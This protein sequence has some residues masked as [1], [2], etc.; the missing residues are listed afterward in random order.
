[1]STVKVNLQGINELDFPSGVTSATT[2]D[3]ITTINLSGGG[4]GITELTGDVAAGPGSGTVA[5]TVEGIQ[6]VS[7]DNVTPQDQQVL[8]YSSTTSK[9]EPATLPASS[10]GTYFLDSASS[11]VV[12]YKLLINSFPTTGEV[13]YSASGTSGSGQ[14]LVAEF[15]GPVGGMG[16]TLIPAGMWEPSIFLSVDSLTQGPQAI[17]KIYTRTLAGVE[18]L[19]LTQNIILTSTSATLYDPT[20]E[21]GNIAVSPTDRMVVKVYLLAGG[22]SSRT[23][24]LY[25]DGTT[26]ASHIHFPTSSINSVQ[27]EF[28]NAQTG[29]SYTVQAA[30]RRY[31]VS[32]T[33]SSPVAVT[34]PQAGANFPNGWFADFNNEGTGTVTITPTTSTIDG[35][36]NI[37]LA[38]YQGI[39]IVSD[40]TNY[41]S[42]RGLGSTVPASLYAGTVGVTIDGSG[43]TPSTGVKG[44]IVLPY[45]CNIVSWYITSDVVGSA[46]FNVKYAASIAGIG[47]TTS[48]VAA[49]PPTLTSAQ[50]ATS[51]TLTGWTTSF[52]A[53]NVLEFDLSSVSSSTRLT[54]QLTLQKV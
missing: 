27:S 14:V 31:L 6:G 41:R 28:V 36:A 53:G 15:V 4:S 10:N 43:S 21:L 8:Q 38:Q 1:M 22:A 45:N 51:S 25:V 49:A 11:D 7:V 39:R 18:T 16:L 34:L 42:V 52:V 33:N 44:Y 12:G 23:L 54:L 47:S 30:D 26:H 2:S 3:G 19:Q 13:T 24:T 20:A 37:T 35:Q 40:G 48:I 5:A 32:F 17:I 29:T 50:A 46:V 9:W